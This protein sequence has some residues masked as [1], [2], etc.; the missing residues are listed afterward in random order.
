MTAVEKGPALPEGW[1]LYKLSSQRKHEPGGTIS[2]YEEG[3][4]NTAGVTAMPCEIVDDYNRA[5]EAFVQASATLERA[6][7]EAYQRKGRYNR[8]GVCGK[9]FCSSGICADC[10]AYWERVTVAAGED[11]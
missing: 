6:R 2:I 10:T 4:S 5:L 11:A 1:A 3:K 8:Y 7:A 9:A